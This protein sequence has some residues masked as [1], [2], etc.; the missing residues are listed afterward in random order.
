MSEHPNVGVIR[1]FYAAFDAD[2]YESAVREFLDDNVI[3]HVA[4]TNPLAGLF[5]GA[6]AVLVAMRR[7]SE[8][9][10]GTLRLTTTSMFAD[11]EH[12]I[13]VHLATAQRDGHVYVAHEVDVFHVG[14]G[15]INEMWSFSEDQAA[16]D[17]MWS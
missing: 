16:T 17:A 8:H 3:W 1:S 7:Y 13:A 14:D 9:S 12:A 4:G 15:R 10:G 5:S 2:D 6:D 11:A